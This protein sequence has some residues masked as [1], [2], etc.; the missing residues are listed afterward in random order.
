MSAS[1]N[2]N[3]ENSNGIRQA[4]RERVRLMS[5][6]LSSPAAQSAAI[7]AGRQI[8]LL[9]SNRPTAAARATASKRPGANGPNL[10][11]DLYLR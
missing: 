9:A 6:R 8:A 2:L 10:K 4:W 1:Q 3:P 5:G 11:C 7:E